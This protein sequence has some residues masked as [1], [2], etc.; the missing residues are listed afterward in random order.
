MK[1]KAKSLSNIYLP[2][3]TESPQKETFPQFVLGYMCIYVLDL[4]EP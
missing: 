4:A 1:K 3:N 2:V